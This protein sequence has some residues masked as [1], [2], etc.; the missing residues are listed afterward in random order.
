MIVEEANKCRR[1]VARGKSVA[2]AAP[3]SGIVPRLADVMRGGMKAVR[4]CVLLGGVL[5]S[6]RGPSRAFRPGGTTSKPAAAGAAGAVRRARPSRGRRT[7]YPRPALHGER[8]NAKML[9]QR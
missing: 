4:W 6:L 1:A 5:A 2:W 9:R 3:R 8:R 7:G